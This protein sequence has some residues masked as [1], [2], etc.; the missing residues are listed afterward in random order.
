MSGVSGTRKLA[1]TAALFAV[2]LVL[3]LVTIIT[4][5]PIPLFV[6]WV[7]LLVVPFFVLGRPER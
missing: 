5:D 1:L 2:A 3:L 7:P 6:M 4:H